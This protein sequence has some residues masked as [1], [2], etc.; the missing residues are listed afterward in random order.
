MA[1]ESGKSQLIKLVLLLIIVFG[2]IGFMM[3]SFMFIP[4]D[5]M[6]TYVLFNIAVDGIG[7]LLIIFLVNMRVWRYISGKT[8]MS[9]DVHQP[10]G[11]IDNVLW[12]R[13][14]YFEVDIDKMEE[15][16]S[17]EQ[18]KILRENEQ[19]IAQLRRAVGAM[20]EIG[21]LRRAGRRYWNWLNQSEDDKHEDDGEE[22]ES[23]Q[24]N[25]DDTETS[26]EVETSDD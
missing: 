22:D 14:G 18:V 7:V 13:D 10:D 15:A 26:K 8:F 20:N 23:E 11:L 5:S 25:V 3:L 9:L 21:R 17:P 12:T 16:M 4:Y 1:W 2:L 19:A 6:S 24:E